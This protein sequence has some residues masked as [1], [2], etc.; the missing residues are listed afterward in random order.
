[1]FHDGSMTGNKSFV[2]LHTFGTLPT[3]IVAGGQIT[4]AP[5]L[6]IGRLA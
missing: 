6:A 2:Q 1:M 3:S 4:T 5:E